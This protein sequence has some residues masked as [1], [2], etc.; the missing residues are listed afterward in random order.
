MHLT[1]LKERRN[2]R[3]LITTYELMNNLEETDRKD[4]IMKRKE[5]KRTRKNCKKEFA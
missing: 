3:D 5:E 2:R 1:T 4:L